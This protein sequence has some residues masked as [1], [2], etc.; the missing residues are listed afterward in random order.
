[1]DDNY[2]HSGYAESENLLAQLE[3][4]DHPTAQRVELFE[5]FLRDAHVHPE[6]S[7]QLSAEAAERIGQ[8]FGNRGQWVAGVVRGFAAE[9]SN[10]TAESLNAWLEILW[11][12]LDS[13]HDQHDEAYRSEFLSGRGQRTIRVT[14]DNAVEVGRPDVIMEVMETLR[15]DVSQT[16]LPEARLGLAPFERVSSIPGYSA[17]SGGTSVGR[18]LAGPYPVAVRGRSA[19]A[20]AASLAQQP[21][22]LD[23]MRVM[24]AGQDAMWWSCSVL[25]QTLYWALLTADGVQG[26]KQ[27]LPTTFAEAIGAHLQTLPL[28][29]ESDLAQLGGSAEPAAARLVALARAA[30][31]V[32]LDRPAIRDAVLAALPT[33][34]QSSIRDYCAA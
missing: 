12:V 30:S 28:I 13:W 6:N 22:D 25:D 20:E 26:G 15:I 2:A 32:M 10:S 14:L 11:S 8:F 19:I 29:L 33:A 17:Q 21:V 7:S 1:M 5:R 31:T 4:I 23:L 24:L 27:E 3:A 34:R 16:S 9:S 18:Y